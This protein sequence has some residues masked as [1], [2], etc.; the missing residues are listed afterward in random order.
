MDCVC[1]KANDVNTVEEDDTLEEYNADDCMEETTRNRADMT[2]EEHAEQDF[3]RR[4]DGQGLEEREGDRRQA[5][6]D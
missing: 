1:E 6:R 3:L 5:R 4:L 2:E